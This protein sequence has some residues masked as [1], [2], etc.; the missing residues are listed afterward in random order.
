MTEAIKTTQLA[1]EE[2]MRSGQ[3]CVKG[4]NANVY[5]ETTQL[6]DE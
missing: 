3:R 4:F 2:G 1:D 6:T 5:I